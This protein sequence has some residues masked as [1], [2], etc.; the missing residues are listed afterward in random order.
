MIL[1]FVFLHLPPTECIL[2]EGRIFPHFSFCSRPYLQCPEHGTREALNTYLSVRSLFIP[3]SLWF[4]YS[5]MDSSDTYSWSN[6]TVLTT[7]E[8]S[9]RGKL[10]GD[11]ASE[12]FHLDHSLGAGTSWYCK[13]LFVGNCPT[14]EA[15]FLVTLAKP[16]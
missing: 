10:S 5:F 1:Y 13:Q 15:P 11:S 16:H 14:Q 2:H 9:G 12:N 3:F 4:V 7:A 6:H 8:G